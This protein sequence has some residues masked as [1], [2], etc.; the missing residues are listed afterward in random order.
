MS[1]VKDIIIRG[2]VPFN[3]T[4]HAGARSWLGLLNRPT[5]G[6]RIT[7]GTRRFVPNGIGKTAMYCFSIEGQEAI[8]YEWIK[9]LIADFR[10]AGG[11]VDQAIVM[12]IENDGP[13]ESMLT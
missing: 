4:D 7:Y 8:R 13:W 3:I 11:T 9:E 6:I 12:D 10:S 5:I 2:E 1:N